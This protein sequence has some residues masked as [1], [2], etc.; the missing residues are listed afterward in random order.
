MS[1]TLE[2]LIVQLVLLHNTDSG[3]SQSNDCKDT[4]LFITRLEIRTGLQVRPSIIT[5]DKGL[6]L[7]G[8]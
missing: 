2:S 3:T 4:P 1:E 8:H 5:L 7:L 6:V